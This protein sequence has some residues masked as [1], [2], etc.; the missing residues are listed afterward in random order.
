MIALDYFQLENSFV[1]FFSLFLSFFLSYLIFFKRCVSLVPCQSGI[2]VPGNNFW[3]R[4][5]WAELTSKKRRRKK[6]LASHQGCCGGAELSWQAK[7]KKKEKK[8]LPSHQGCCGDAELSWQAKKKKKK[9]VLASEPQNF[10]PQHPRLPGAWRDNWYF[11][12]F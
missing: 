8:V 6:V 12:A 11:V 5:C 9:K 3:T 7:K 2:Q 4:G 1:S 10:H